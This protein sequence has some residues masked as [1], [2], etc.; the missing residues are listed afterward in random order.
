MTASY[1]A[2]LSEHRRIHATGPVPLDRIWTLPWANIADI[3]VFKDCVFADD[4]WV[5]PTAMVSAGN[6][7]AN[8]RTVNF[9]KAVPSEWLRDD[10]RT[11]N[12]IR[13]LKRIAF[14]N[15]TQTVPGLRQR[16]KPAQPNI[17]VK[18]TNL[19]FNAARD[20]SVMT[21]RTPVAKTACPDG[22]PVFSSLPPEAFDRL[23]EIHPT[24]F[25]ACIQRL[26]ALFN[27][28]LFDDWPAGDIGVQKPESTVILP[29]SDTAFTEILR[30]TSFLAQIQPDLEACYAEISG[31][32]ADEKGWTSYKNVRPYRNQC[33]AV[34]SGKIVYP[35]LTFQF[36]LDIDGENKTI[37]R[38][39]AWPVHTLNGVKSLLWLCQAANAIIVNTATGGRVSEMRTLS[40][41]PLTR[42]NGMEGLTGLTFKESEDPKGSTR[43]WPLPRQAVEA[44]QRQQSL[45]TTLGYLGDYLWA[46]GHNNT[47]GVANVDHL[48]SSFG[49]RVHTLD[50]TPFGDLDGTISPHRFRKTMSRL[51][52]L[53]LEGASEVLYTVLG[54]SDIDVTL[55]YML[56][57]PEFR[58]D[59][60]KVRRE[61]QDVRRKH[62][63]SESEDCGGPAAETLR[64]A[65]AELLQKAHKLGVDPDDPEVF[66]TI[67]PFIEKVRDDVFCTSDSKQKGLCSKVTGKR[68]MGACSAICIFRLEMAAASQRN[69]QAIEQAIKML[70]IDHIY[71]GARPFYQS[72]ILANLATFP[73]TIDAFANDNRLRQ[74]LLDCDPR[75]FDPLPLQTRDKLIAYM[76]A[77]A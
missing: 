65:K 13:R 18:H 1:Q 73:K 38:F 14:L 8:A 76:E 43:H 54:H 44:I 45:L 26:N 21:D 52:G 10:L 12:L 3:K 49:R 31:I 2:A 6:Q 57:D 22:D 39:N 61:V 7:A 46:P 47:T 64:A 33:L 58:Q 40:R 66:R 70:S 68:D 15:F 59:A 48:I 24:F 19:L 42:F 35:G 53:A 16:L 63:I 36:P 37:Q 55:G 62:I 50:G 25:Q 74:A 28:G 32:T 27:A 5:I 20:A 75:H 51:A 34:W 67:L 17:W 9:A 69:Q 29:I 72:Q 77:S 41:D 56:S 23:R 11:E 60:D 4:V 30:A 71:A